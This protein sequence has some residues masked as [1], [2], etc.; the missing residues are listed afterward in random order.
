MT[1]PFAAK[2]AD[3]FAPP[4]S[5]RCAARRQPS[6]FMYWMRFQDHQ[7]LTGLIRSPVPPQGDPGPPQACAPPTGAPPCAT[8]AAAAS[9]LPYP[10]RMLCLRRGVGHGPTFLRGPLPLYCLMRCPASSLILKDSF[11]ASANEA[12]SWKCCKM[13]SMWHVDTVSI[14]ACQLRNLPGRCRAH[15]CLAARLML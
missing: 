9:M 13:H 11:D 5:A 15:P 8:P 3:G 12:R 10:A 7:P 2:K 6:C 4:S 1:C 14:D